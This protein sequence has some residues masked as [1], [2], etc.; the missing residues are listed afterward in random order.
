M[1]ADRAVDARSGPPHALTS[2]WRSDSRRCTR[3]D[4]P[5]EQAF[6]LIGSLLASLIA[7]R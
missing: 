3:Q 1:V 4:R 6:V 7:L 2:T 5:T